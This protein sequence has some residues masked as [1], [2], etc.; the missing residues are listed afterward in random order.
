LE[1]KKEY[2]YAL[3]N[4]LIFAL[5]SFAAIGAPFL[6]ESEGLLS[7]EQRDLWVAF[8]VLAYIVFMPL[9]MLRGMYRYF[10]V[11]TP[12]ENA[13]RFNPYERLRWL[14]KKLKK[15]PNKK[16]FLK[17]KTKLEE[18]YANEIESGR[19]E[20]LSPAEQLKEMQAGAEEKFQTKLQEYEKD[21]AGKQL[22]LGWDGPLSQMPILLGV[23]KALE[24]ISENFHPLVR[25]LVVYS[26]V[27]HLSPNF[28]H[29]TRSL[30]KF[31]IPFLRSELG[32]D[33]IAHFPL[34]DAE[35][36]EDEEAVY[37][38]FEEAFI[39]VDAQISTALETAEEEHKLAQEICADV[40]TDLTDTIEDPDLITRF[41][42]T[43]RT[44]LKQHDLLAET[45]EFTFSSMELGT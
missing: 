23:G 30:G 40:C 28:S 33:W 42:S 45:A 13:N 21:P 5:I 38:D 36:A 32:D 18:N 15:K 14:E 37:A 44:S 27:E 22:G 4:L 8:G 41:I 12:A 1:N 24:S 2:P 3:R 39:N 43:A 31:G 29:E 34:T 20:T 6:L 35:L 10:F 19:Y 9:W 26:A 11:P 7:S 16:A 17:E 25:L